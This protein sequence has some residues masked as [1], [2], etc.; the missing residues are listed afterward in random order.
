MKFTSVPGPSMMLCGT[1]K[2]FDSCK[3]KKVNLKKCRLKKLL[4]YY[5]MEDMG[6]KLDE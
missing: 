4:D 3:K 2:I 1:A 5:H 6:T